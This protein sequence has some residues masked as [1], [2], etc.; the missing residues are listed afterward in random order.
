ML[1]GLLWLNFW[2]PPKD[3]NFNFLFPLV[4]SQVQCI[5]RCGSRPTKTALY[6]HQTV[7]D[8]LIYESMS[9]LTEVTPTSCSASVLIWPWPW[10]TSDGSEDFAGQP[11]EESD[12]PMGQPWADFLLNL[13]VSRVYWPLKINSTVPAGVHTM[14]FY[15][16]R[17][18][19]V[20][21]PALFI[22]S[23]SNHLRRIFV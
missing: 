10:W 8:S 5:T 18:V 16:R 11:H 19:C 7:C 14:A 20:F 13:I 2:R 6:S 3:F 23:Q 9:Y 1:C 22:S 15:L 17:L 21:I 12:H 4:C